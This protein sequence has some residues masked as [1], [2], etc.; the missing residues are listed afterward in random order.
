MTPVEQAA[1]VYDREP[2]AGTFREDLEEYLLHGMVHS[3]ATAFVM[4]RYTT[5][6][7]SLTCPLETCIHVHLAAGDVSEMF[8]FPHMPCKWISFERKNVM[9]FHPYDQL[10]RR[11][12]YQ[13]E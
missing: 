11:C 3:A 6:E 13:K 9:R 2:C 4:A 1:A 10:K 5:R 12:T 8:N 7:D